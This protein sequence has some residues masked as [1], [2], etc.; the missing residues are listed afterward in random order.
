MI[1]KKQIII[2]IIHVHIHI[3]L[4]IHNNVVMNTQGV[5]PRESIESCSWTCV[6]YHMVRVCVFMYGQETK[7]R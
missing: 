2:K 7:S 1:Q 4:V 6:Y 3:H 5:Y